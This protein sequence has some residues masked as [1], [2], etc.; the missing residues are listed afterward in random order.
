[1]KLS[2]IIV[3]YNV[4]HFL[5]QCLQSVFKALQNVDGEVWVVDNN[6]VDGS[7]AMIKDKFPTVKLIAS[8]DNLGFSKGNNIAIKESKG[9]ELANKLEKRYANYDYSFYVNSKKIYTELLEKLKNYDIFLAEDKFFDSYYYPSVFVQEKHKSEIDDKVNQNYIRTYNYGLTKSPVNVEEGK[10][11]KK[12]KR[13]K[14]NK[15][16]KRRKR[17]N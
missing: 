14:K 15:K 11:R 2:V 4:Q 9:E 5:E 7:V 13:K 12:S 3:N 17:Q 8:K 6:S 10:L 1:M 16:S